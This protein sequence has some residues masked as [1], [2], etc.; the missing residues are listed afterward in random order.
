MKD[1][2]LGTNYW[3][4]NAGADMWRHWNPEAVAHD[5]DVLAENGVQVLRVFPNWRDFQPV[6]PSFTSSHA[7]RE[8]GMAGDVWPE[9]PYYLDETMLERFSVFCRLAQERGLRLIVGLLTG[10]MSGR[11]YIPSALFEKNIY[12][13]PTALY[14]EQLFVKGFVLRMKHEPAIYAWDLGNECNCMDRADD[15]IQACN[16]T[17]TIVHAIRAYDPDRPIVSG[18]HSLE[19][20]GVWNIQDQAEWTDILT[21]H[22]Y[23]FWVEHCQIDGLTSL[24]T[25]LHATAQTR[26][27]A[28]VG[29][30]P[31]LV[32]EIGSMGP[33][34]ASEENAAGFLTI[35]LW[36][37]WAHGSPGVLWWCANEQ[38]HLTAAPYD[39]KMF[40]RELGMLDAQMQ[41]KP[42]LL[43]MK[44]FSKEI[45]QLNLD[46]PAC[47]TDAVC[48]LSRGQDHWG[49]AYMSF[50]LAKQAGLTIDFAYCGQ[51]P[52]DSSVYFLPSV[53]CEVMNKRN[54]DIL[55]QKIYD[56]ATLYIS[57]HDGAFSEFEELTGLQVETSF[58]A[59][60][61][62]T[63]DWENQKFPYHKTYQIKLRPT[64]A[65]V[66][67][68][69]EDGNPL[70]TVASYGKGTVYFLNFPLEEMLLTQANAFESAYYT[71][72]AA[73][74]H[75][76]LQQKGITRK[77]PAVGLTLHPGESADYAVLVNYSDRTQEPQIEIRDRYASVHVLRGN[78]ERLDAFDAAILR[79]EKRNG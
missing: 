49:I 19:L 28:T 46:L 57:M 6:E 61:D 74:A 23:P 56:G 41:P 7:L 65:R 5:L 8:Y 31:C 40:E 16:W 47:S 34:I 37:N 70:F 24:R 4:S 79:L 71:L 58:R 27:Y 55:K 14:F 29:Q 44:A 67:A 13:D 26:Y 68:R 45:K 17:A 75:A 21:T 60:L 12:T 59:P 33:M 36:S 52:P 62:G 3:A 9:N 63:M 18:M 25:L 53:H 22:P 15:R 76:L 69:E 11:L 64:R 66:L 35:N 32:K 50:I 2:L 20:E 43:A 10:W 38:A 1:F 77:N 54:Y 72:Y 78:M 39:W 30:K 51:T 42:M 48:L 73:V